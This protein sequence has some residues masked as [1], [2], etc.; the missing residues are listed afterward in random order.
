MPVMITEYVQ[1]KTGGVAKDITIPC[2]WNK[3]KMGS[4]R[5]ALEIQYRT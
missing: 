2:K 3:K 1:D 4:Q 5:T